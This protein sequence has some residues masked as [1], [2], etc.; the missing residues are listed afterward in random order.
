[1][2]CN[3]VSIDLAK[4]VFQLCALDEQ[5][6]VIF[7]KQIRRDKLLHELRQIEPTLVVME[8]CYSANPWGRRFKALGHTVKCIPAHVVK[9]FVRGNKNDANDALAIAEAARRPNVRFVE[10]KSVE[11]QDVQSLQRI[12]ERLLKNRIGDSNQLRGLLAEYGIVLPVKHGA[13][14]KYVP[15][16]L[17]DAE[18]ELSITARHF[19][20]RL[21]NNVQ[22]LTT[23]IE[24]VDGILISLLKDNKAY[25]RILN[26]P[27]VG[28]KVAA[29]FLA[30]VNDIHVF[31]NGRQ[32]AAWIGLT[33][34]QYASGD[35]SRMGGITKRGNQSLR[36]M[37]ILGARAVLNWCDKTNDNLRRW[38]QHIKKRMHGCKAVVALANKLARII[39]VVMAKEV[40][41]DVKK[42]CA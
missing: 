10:I 34:A 13:L 27:G 3:L 28:A 38:A 37:L 11:Q 32:F 29:T 9:P 7:N 6:N 25:Q 22:A 5:N 12:R 35:K 39:W 2:K 23:Q 4:N 17:E 33:P 20:E 30:S 14:K 18:N 36:K 19:I 21:H 41:F 8:A 31:K 40:E 42:A 16:I 26:V 1:M 24:E 15:D